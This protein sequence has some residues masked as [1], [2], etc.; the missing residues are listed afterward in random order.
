MTY[1]KT[2]EGQKMDYAIIEEASRMIQGVG[3]G[4]I[5]EK[6]AQRLFSLVKDGNTITDVE[7]DTIEYISKNYNWA[8]NAKAWFNK[9]WKAWIQAH[10]LVPLT[11]KELIGKHFAKEDV[12][13]DPIDREARMHALLAATNETNQ[14]HDEIGLQIQLQDGTLVEV[15]SNFIEAGNEFVQLKGGCTIPVRAIKKVEI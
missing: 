7:K 9:E 5:S 6:D 10:T 3:D 13:P 1:Y 14:D 11:I 4:R 15:F 8:S 12:L 2:I